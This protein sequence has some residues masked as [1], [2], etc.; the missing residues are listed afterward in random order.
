VKKSYTTDDLKVAIPKTLK[1]LLTATVGSLR[2]RMPKSK[3]ADIRF[4]L[5]HLVS[6]GLLKAALI[7]AETHTGLELVFY[8][9]ESSDEVEALYNYYYGQSWVPYRLASM[10]EVT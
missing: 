3:V 8:R 6:I 4:V 7:P 10:E 1:M 5:N 2:S 9:I